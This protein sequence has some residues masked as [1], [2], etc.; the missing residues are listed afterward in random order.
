MSILVI[1]GIYAIIIAERID[2]I[3]LQLEFSTSNIMG[4]STFQ[5]MKNFTIEVE[6]F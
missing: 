4:S 6:L 2:Y 5:T 1:S 3:L